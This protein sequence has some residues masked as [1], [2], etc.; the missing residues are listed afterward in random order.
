MNFTIVTPS[1]RNSKWLKLCIASVA[2]QEGVTFEH[3]VQDA[4]SDDETKDW[5]PQDKRVKAFIEKDRGMYDAINRGWHRAQG[6]LVAYLNCD[7][8]YL[9]GALRGVLEYAEKNPKLDL[10]VAHTVVVDPD[11]NYMCHRRSLMPRMPHLWIRLPILTCA[12]F[13]RRRALENKQLFF[14]PKW[15]DLGDQHWFIDMARRGVPAGV[16][17]QYT[18]VFT[19]TGDNMNLKPNAIREKQVTREMMP[20]FVRRF[21]PALVMYHRLRLLA[22]GTF[23]QQPF[24]YSLYTL[25]DAIRR[26]THHV[27]RPTP[28]WRGLDGQLRR[29]EGAGAW[30]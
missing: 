23:F 16:I 28:R 14:D 2:D 29:E 4:C 25:K 1:F 22:S 12:T 26:T 20:G 17:P 15:R 30:S 10:M 8:Q 5:L 19:E 13:L 6:D 27:P 3:I 24:D 9:P 7:E 11:G 21:R 18:S